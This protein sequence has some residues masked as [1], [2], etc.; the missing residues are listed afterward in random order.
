[1]VHFPG[2]KHKAA[3]AV[4][5]HPTGPMNAAATSTSAVPLPFDHFGHSFMTGLR[6]V[7]PPPTS[8]LATID[9]QLASSA[10]SALSTMAADLYH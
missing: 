1:M 2:I 8:R 3:D 5:R 4:S 9:D 6:R 7:E 10:S